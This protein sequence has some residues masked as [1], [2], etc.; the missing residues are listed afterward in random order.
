M[1]RWL[2]ISRAPDGTESILSRS[3]FLAAREGQSFRLNLNTGANY[4]LI[5]EE[6]Y[7]S[8]RITPC[9][10]LQ[11]SVGRSAATGAAQSGSTSASDVNPPCRRVLKQ[12][13]TS[14]K[15]DK[16]KRRMVNIA[17]ARFIIPNAWVELEAVP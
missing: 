4:Y 16:V 13:S 6:H 2:L 7:K 15:Q 14:S 3:G 9:L 11:G 17:A 12:A 1:K 5:R 8:P 10:S